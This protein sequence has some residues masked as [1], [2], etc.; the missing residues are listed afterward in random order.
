MKDLHDLQQEGHRQQTMEVQSAT[1]IK[2]KG[3]LVQSTR[4]WLIIKAHKQEFHGFSWNFMEFHGFSWN[5]MGFHGVFMGFHGFSLI[6][7]GFHGFS[8][9]F[10]GFH[11]FSCWY[12]LRSKDRRICNPLVT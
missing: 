2:P 8:W 1:I 5:F 3:T 10:M 11:G 4:Y 9:I 12:T 6:F 7:M